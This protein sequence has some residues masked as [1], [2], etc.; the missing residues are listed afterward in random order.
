MI[1]KLQMVEAH[2]SFYVS[3]QVHYST[4]D[5]VISCKGPIYWEVHDKVMDPVLDQI[6][7]EIWWEVCGQL[8]GTN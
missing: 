7:N 1:T 5:Q 3:H 4:A 8:K 2:S 6:W